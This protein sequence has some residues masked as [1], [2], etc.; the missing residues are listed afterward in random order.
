MGRD[1]ELTY[2]QTW[3]GQNVFGLELRSDNYALEL[4]CDLSIIGQFIILSFQTPPV[5]LEP[6]HYRP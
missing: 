4:K 1:L 5:T 2:Y 3:K 6:L